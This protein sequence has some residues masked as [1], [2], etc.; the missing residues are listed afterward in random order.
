VSRVL[1]GNRGG[2]AR[3]LFGI[4]RHRFL[5][6]EAVVVRDAERVEE[7]THHRPLLGEVIHDEHARREC[8]GQARHAREVT[9]L[10]IG[11]EPI[12]RL[13]PEFQLLG[14]ERGRLRLLVL[15]F[16]VA[17]QRMRGGHALLGGHS[18]PQP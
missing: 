6:D 10:A 9:R 15:G 5:V 3:N 16:L 7:G 4:G 2:G 8:V 12:D 18:L 11:I 17:P 13:G 1:P 14:D